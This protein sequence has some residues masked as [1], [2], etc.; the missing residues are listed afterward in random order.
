MKECLRL[1]DTIF[2]VPGERNGQKET[3]ND[4]DDITEFMGYMSLTN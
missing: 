2:I 3:E 4:R 1:A